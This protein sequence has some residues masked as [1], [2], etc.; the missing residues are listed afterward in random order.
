[1]EDPVPVVRRD[2]RTI[3]GHL[4]DHL[5]L[6][7]A[8][9]AVLCDGRGDPC[10]HAYGPARS[11]RLARVP[12][13][14]VEG[15][16]ELHGI[17]EGHGA[18]RRVLAL[19][20]TDR[21]SGRRDGRVEER[22]DRQPIPLAA[23]VGA[24]VEIVAAQ[25]RDRGIGIQRV[26][27]EGLTMVVDRLKLEQVLVNLLANAVKFTP[28]GGEIA[29]DAQAVPQAVV[30][31]V[32]DTGEGILPEDLERIFEPFVQTGPRGVRR[33]RGTGLGLA[34]CR[35]IVSLHG[36]TIHAE[37]EGPGRGSTFVVRIPVPAAEHQ[38]A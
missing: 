26:V 29:V 35:Q 31:R 18:L 20:P 8:F 25:A 27:P 9:G 36:G 5:R 1:M 16:P 3:I 30:V 21:R 15:L 6:L 28:P 2:P 24:S 14:V 4:H 22:L 32:R 13:E 33:P 37:S 11:G 23:L 17:A 10:P 7:P 19:D 34:I 12:D 38:A